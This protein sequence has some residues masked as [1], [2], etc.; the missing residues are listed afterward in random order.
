[1]S[2]GFATEVSDVA[3]IR[4]EPSSHDSYQAD[5]SSKGLVYVFEDFELRAET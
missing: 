2:A 3:E 1:M 4:G 5:S